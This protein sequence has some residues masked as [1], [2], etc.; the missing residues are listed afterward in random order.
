VP[1]QQVLPAGCAQPFQIGDGVLGPWNDQNVKAWRH[2]WIAQVVNA[3][4]RFVLERFKIRIVGDTRQVYHS[5]SH[6]LVAGMRR[7][8][9][10]HGGILLR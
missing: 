6:W 3:D 8:P 10:Q 9:V 4:I 2:A 7:E 5:D 1:D